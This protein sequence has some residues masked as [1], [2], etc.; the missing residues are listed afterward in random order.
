MGLIAAISGDICG[1]RQAPKDKWLPALRAALSNFGNEGHDW[2]IIRGDSFQLRLPSILLC[3][4]CCIVI[5][6]TLKAQADVNVRMAIGI[7]RGGV[8][9]PTISESDGD[10][11]VYSGTSLDKLKS[12]RLNLFLKSNNTVF[13]E[14]I[15]PSLDMASI[16]MSRWLPNYAAAVLVKLEYSSY[17][18]SQ[19][20]EHM[21]LAQNTVSERLSRAELR[22]LEAFNTSFQLQL[23]DTF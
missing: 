15:N 5:S 21:G 9:G 22:T 11:Y 19:L 7:G 14:K 16:I 23:K 4:H 6:A 2:Q 1:S 10:A 17:T 3:L 20:G 12:R 18:Q 13:D 8:N